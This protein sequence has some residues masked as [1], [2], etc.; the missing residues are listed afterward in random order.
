MFE[1]VALNMPY[2]FLVL[3][4]AIALWLPRFRW[5]GVIVA[6][7]ALFNIAL[8]FHFENPNV[9]LPYGLRVLLASNVDYVTA[10]FMLI[11]LP[12]YRRGH[13]FGTEGAS[14]QAFALTLFIVFNG[15][16][17]VNFNWYDFSLYSAYIPGIFLLNL[18]QLN[19]LRRSIYASARRDAPSMGRRPFGYGLWRS[20]DGHYGPEHSL[21][22]KKAS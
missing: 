1:T 14:G 9:G 21:T 20:H 3:Y 18:I 7:S 19:F 8:M 16:I 13:Y 15:I 11:A 5:V 17:F 2:L 22:D 10:V 4:G 6:V 12:G